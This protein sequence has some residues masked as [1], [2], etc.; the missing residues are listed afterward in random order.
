M[1]AQTRPMNSCARFRAPFWRREL[2]PSPLCAWVHHPEAY[3]YG[4]APFQPRPF[5]T[6]KPIN[7][8]AHPF[9]LGRLP[10]RSL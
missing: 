9:S 8:A 10:P 2:A 7:M 6:P 3:K 5:P 1:T 4:R